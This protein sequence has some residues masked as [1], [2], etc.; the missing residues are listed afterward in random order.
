MLSDSVEQVGVVREPPV[1]AINRQ[2][3]AFC[4]DFFIKEDTLMKKSNPQSALPVLLVAALI[5]TFG[6]G[7]LAAI[8]DRIGA[9]L[10]DGQ[11]VARRSSLVARRSS[12]VSRGT[13]H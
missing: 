11:L 6:G 4:L 8:G 9:K 2:R 7:R 10:A 13:G 3:L 12:H 1:Q 5:M